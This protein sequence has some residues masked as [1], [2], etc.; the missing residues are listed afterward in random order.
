ME[1]ELAKT[2]GSIDGV[3]SASVHLVIPKLDVFA[4]DDKKPT[5]SVLL[6]TA[7]SKQLSNQQITSIVNLVAGGVEGL[8]P[9]DISVTDDKGRSLAVAGQGVGSGGGN[10]DQVCSHFAVRD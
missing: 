2:I 9:T 4:D 7:G 6:K 5:A 3:S 10:D 1:G 8:N